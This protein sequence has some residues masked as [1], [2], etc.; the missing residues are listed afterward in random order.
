M[1][2]LY[3]QPVVSSGFHR[4]CRTI[5]DSIS[6]PQNR[7]D[8]AGYVRI[9]DLS[10]ISLDAKKGE[11]RSTTAR[12]LSVVRH[13]LVAFIAP[14]SL[15]SFG[16]E[17]L[18]ALS[19]CSN[20][21][22]LD[23]SVISLQLDYRHICITIEALTN[24]KVLALPQN[25]EWVPLLGPQVP[26]N[27]P[28]GLEELL[29]F[30]EPQTLLA[31]EVLHRE[32]P[33]LPP[34]LTSL[35]I[36]CAFIL[37]E[38]LDILEILGPQLRSLTLLDFDEN[39]WEFDA[40]TPSLGEIL[41]LHPNLEALCISST[42]VNLDALDT[43]IPKDHP[44]QALHFMCFCTIEDGSPLCTDESSFDEEEQESLG[45]VKSHCGPN[46]KR[47]HWI[48]R[49][50]SRFSPM[51][52]WKALRP[53]VKERAHGSSATYSWKSGWSWKIGKNDRLVEA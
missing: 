30:D 1:P 40:T 12:L 11:Y 41:H 18:V 38:M 34:S 27:W 51:I 10:N 25:V 5:C 9:L 17:S 4:F 2:M 21:T 45:I 15:C 48:I 14:I 32:V 49:E 13:S 19:K 16:T 42:F 50:A 52:S 6:S 24:L 3:E 33:N 43:D 20:L 22:R 37:D 7:P 39:R 26:F 47:L 28:P 8:F 44:L 23:L 35:T 46:L 29:T 53:V 31:Y 36:A